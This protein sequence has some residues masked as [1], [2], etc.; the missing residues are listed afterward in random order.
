MSPVQ[1]QLLGGVRARAL[2]D[3]RPR[4]ELHLHTGRDGRLALR[5]ILDA[6]TGCSST[7]IFEQKPLRNTYHLFG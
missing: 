4:R 7:W 6:E 1:S 3:A 2:N 5:G